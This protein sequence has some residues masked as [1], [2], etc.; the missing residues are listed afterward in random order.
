MTKINNITDYIKCYEN[1]LDLDVCEQII[2]S[3]NFKNFKKATVGDDNETSYRNCYV[4]KLDK[5]YE[6]KIFIAVGNILKIY[7]DTFKFFSTG[8]T[9]E[10]TGYNH[11]I[12]K[13]SEKGEYKTHV[14]HFDLQPRVLSCSL[15]LN[16]NYDGGDFSF[17]ND[18][19]VVKKKSG[20]AVVFPSNFC[21][22]HSVKPV[23]NG[24][25]HAIVTWIV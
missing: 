5:V 17:F 14:D 9:T 3:T 23:S 18:E 13:G 10:D 19:Y 25:R 24:D 6:D 4:S 12:Y 15:I 7:S 20:S 21:F 8:L 2:K 16:E 11:L 1:I 22:P